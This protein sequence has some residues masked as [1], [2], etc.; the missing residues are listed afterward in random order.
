[1]VINMYKYA[2]VKIKELIDEETG[3]VTTTN[4]V[5]NVIVWDGVTPWT[6]PENTE[7]FNVENVRAGIGYT[8]E[9]GVFTAPLNT[10]Q[11]A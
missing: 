7:V 1:M 10:E 5:D 3:N 8:Y 4:V 6:P 11:T 9:N 2:L